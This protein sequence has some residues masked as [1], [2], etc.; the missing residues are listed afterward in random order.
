MHVTL[1]R[2]IQGG[3]K[4]RFICRVDHAARPLNSERKFLEARNKRARDTVAMIYG[5]LFAII[6]PLNH[7]PDDY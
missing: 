6:N 2:E 7:R 4:N 5:L 3:M 1:A